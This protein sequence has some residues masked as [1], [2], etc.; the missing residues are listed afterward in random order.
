MIMDSVSRA[1][2]YDGFSSEIRMGLEYLAGCGVDTMVGKYPLASDVIAIVSEYE[3]K[4]DFDGRYEVHSRTLD[5]QYPLSGLEVVKFAPIEALKR[6]GR[7]VPTRDLYWYQGE[8]EAA[9]LTLGNGVFAIFF[10]GEPHGPG[11]ARGNLGR[12]KKLTVKITIP[13]STEKFP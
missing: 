11:L 7:Y 12:I 3:T 9:E 1:L 4:R 5:I 6:V 2:F 13:N 10:P 8:R